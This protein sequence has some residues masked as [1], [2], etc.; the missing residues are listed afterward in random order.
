M[1]FTGD[2]S[3]GQPECRLDVSRAKEVLGFEAQTNLE[4][5]LKKTMAWY[6]NNRG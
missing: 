3:D 5:G 2:V 1:I 6:M 4:D